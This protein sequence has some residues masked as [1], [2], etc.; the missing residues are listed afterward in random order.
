MAIQFNA[1]SIFEIGIQIERNGRNFYL[2]AAKRSSEETLKSLFTE[3]AN[4]EDDHIKLFQTL[5][6][7]LPDA[8]KEENLFDPD[9]EFSMYLQAAS[10]SHVF[11]VSTDAAQLAAQC[12]SSSEAIELALTFEKDSIIYYTTMKKVVAEHLGREKIDMLI[13]EELKHIAI[14]S[15]KKKQIAT[16]KR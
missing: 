7:E 11:I 2:E 1:E 9:G 10:E 8:A 6:S 13:G 16:Q 12:K 4:W 3:L 5:L 15:K 14:L